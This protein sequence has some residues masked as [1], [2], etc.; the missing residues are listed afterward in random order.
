MFRGVEFVF[1][2]LGELSGRFGEEVL[3]VWVE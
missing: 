2:R 3:G 1:N